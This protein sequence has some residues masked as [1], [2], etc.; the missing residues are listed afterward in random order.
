MG[1]TSLTNFL[2]KYDGYAKNVTLSYKKQGSYDTA[3][4][5]FCSIFT[6]VLLLYLVA[7]DIWDSF[8]PPGK[9]TS[10]RSVSLLQSTDG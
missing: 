4:G 8:A 7:V 3:I 9:Y 1:K 10:S 6:F 5:G 2:K